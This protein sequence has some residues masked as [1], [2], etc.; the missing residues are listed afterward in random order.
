MERNLGWHFLNG[1]KLRDGTIAP[2]HGEWLEFKAPL[3]ICES[4]LHFSKTPFDA[5]K[6]APGNTLCLI[7]WGGE[8]LHDTDKSVCSRRKII[9]RMDAEEMLHYFAR[10]QAVSVLHL[11]HTKPPEVVCDYLMMGDDN[12]RDAARDAAWDAAWDAARDAAR[13]AAW[14][15]AWD[16]AR[17]AARAAARK[18]FNE[19]VYECFGL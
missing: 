6:Y 19:L 14:D 11:W 9:V 16:A 3:R 8:F 7:E 17:A 4:G 5:L 18:D 13:D 2:A 15:A 10:M 1:D 12:L